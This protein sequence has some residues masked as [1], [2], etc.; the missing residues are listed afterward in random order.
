MAEGYLDRGQFR[1]LRGGATEFDA[2]S[3]D[4]LDEGWSFSQP[5]GS[6][7]LWYQ[8]KGCAMWNQTQIDAFQH[9]D[10]Q[11]QR[12]GGGESID[13]MSNSFPNQKIMYRCPLGNSMG[14]SP[15]RQRRSMDPSS[16]EYDSL[17][18]PLLLPNTNIGSTGSMEFSPNYIPVST[19]QQL[20]PVQSSGTLGWDGTAVQKGCTGSPRGTDS[21]TE[22]FTFGS[23]LEGMTSNQ[24]ADDRGLFETE[25]SHSLDES[26]DLLI[27]DKTMLPNNLPSDAKPNISTAKEIKSQKPR[28]G[29]KKGKEAGKNLKGKEGEQTRKGKKESN[30]AEKKRTGLKRELSV[31][32]LQD[33]TCLTEKNE[34]E[35]DTERSKKK[36]RFVEKGVEEEE[37]SWQKVSLASKEIGVTKRREKVPMSDS[38]LRGCQILQWAFGGH[39]PKT[40][41]E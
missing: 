34:I 23:F 36:R 11:L 39:L 10:F 14:Q 9:L 4:R 26:N 16:L 8:R 37:P 18:S 29:K 1:Y 25:G 21:C 17:F 32:F 41:T 28:G 2:R 20:I 27:F 3:V 38:D 33:T 35:E 19:N 5:K 7:N 15:L 22:S 40:W 12:S 24:L 30:K 6:E 13:P 31:D